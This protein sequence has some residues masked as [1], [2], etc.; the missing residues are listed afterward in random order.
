MLQ[1]TQKVTPNFIH[2]II[3]ETDAHT[4]A[5]TRMTTRSDFFEALTLCRIKISYFSHIYQSS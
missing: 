5:H 3:K 4:T 2:L 1:T